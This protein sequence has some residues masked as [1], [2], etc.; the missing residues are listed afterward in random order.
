MY[1]IRRKNNTTI[2]KTTDTRREAVNWCAKELAKRLGCN[3]DVLP[4]MSVSRS[5]DIEKQ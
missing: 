4:P 3:V 1:V 2:L 5:Y